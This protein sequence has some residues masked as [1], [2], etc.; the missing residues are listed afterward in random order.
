MFTYRASEVSKA[1]VD[2]TPDCKY[3]PESRC[4]LGGPCCVMVCCRK[5]FDLWIC[6]GR[7]RRCGAII[8]FPFFKLGSRA[9]VVLPVGPVVMREEC[10]RQVEVEP[11]KSRITPF[12]RQ[13]GTCKGAFPIVDALAKVAHG[14][15]IP[16]H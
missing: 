15:G 10:D 5:R 1:H 14:I 7:G 3:A 9:R 2:L 8:P 13:A 16:A 6:R 12:P 4:K 11:C